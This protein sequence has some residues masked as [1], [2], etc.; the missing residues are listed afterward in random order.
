MIKAFDDHEK[1]RELVIEKIAFIIGSFGIKI[2]TL[3]RPVLLN[4]PF[5]LDMSKGFFIVLF[6]IACNFVY[7]VEKPWHAVYATAKIGRILQVLVVIFIQKFVVLP[8]QLDIV[9]NQKSSLE[10]VSFVVGFCNNPD[11]LLKFIGQRRL[12][13]IFGLVFV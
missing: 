4:E 1:M 5:M 9:N 6:C 7:D 2:L 3:L 12:L 10:N 11:D 13:I 8:S